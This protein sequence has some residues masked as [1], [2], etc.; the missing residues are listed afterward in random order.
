MEPPC[1]SFHVVLVSAAWFCSPNSC[2]ADNKVQGLKCGLFLVPLSKREKNPPR[3]PQQA[4][5]QVS[6]ARTDMG[7]PSYPNHC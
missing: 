6:T 1:G 4:F 7:A 3:N 2:I 5:P